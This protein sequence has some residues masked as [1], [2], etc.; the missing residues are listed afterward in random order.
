[1]AQTLGFHPAA[2]ASASDLDARALP[3]LRQD[4]RLIEG[5]AS[6][7]GTEGAAQWRIHDPLAQRFYRVG[8]E[9][10]EMLAHWGEGS[11]GALRAALRRDGR[12]TPSDDRIISLLEFLQRHELLRPVPQETFARVRQQT[13][14]SRRSLGSRLLHGYLFFKVP[15]ARPDAFLRRTLPWVAMFFAPALWWTAALLAL[16]GLYLVSR[17]WEGFLATFP[18]MLSVSGIAAFGLSLVL[19]KTLHELGHGYTAAR[20]G[21]RVS[22]MGVAFVVMAPILYTDTTDA[23]RLPHR[24][25]RVLIDAAGMLVELLVAVL[26]TL[27]WVFLPPGALRHAAFALAT[28]GWVLSLAINLN[29]LMRFDGYYLFSDLIGFPNLQERAFAMGRWWL[30]ELLFGFGDTQPEPARPR[31]KAF[32]VGFAYA[33]WLYRF[34]LFL[35]I[36]LLVYHWFFKLLGIFLFAVEIGWFVVLPVWREIKVWFARRR[37]VGVRAR[38]TASLLLTLAAML[39]V[40]LP[41]TVRIPAVLTAARQAPVFAPRPARLEIVHVRPR[42]PVRAGQVLIELAAPE[43]DQ[44]LRTAR[45]RRALLRERLARRSADARDLSESTVLAHELQLE[46][47]RIEGLQRERARL[48]LRAPLDGVVAELAAELSP[49]RW[50][51]D[52]TR[53]AVIAAPGELEARGYVDASDLR[54]IAEGDR[55]HFVEELRLQ[56]ARELQLTRIADAASERIENWLLASTH[57]GPVPAREQDGHTIPEH[58]VF[59]V[60]AAVASDPSGRLPTTELRG[61]MQLRGSPE[62][63][64]ARMFSRIA[65]VLIREAG[66]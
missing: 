8:R 11:V 49:G 17:Q 43:L 15:L 37:E 16:A 10:V 3:A 36:A 19:V 22:T 35:G 63:L 45:E 46:G 18:D 40:P 52:K 27:A 25:Q 9:V 24:R 2:A 12:E 23:W 47:E 39:L 5:G 60:T 44:A 13:A 62:S 59:E 1:M 28:T 66:A 48:R 26:A 53:L 33:T 65:H 21:A 54:R 34:F 29:P 30:R 64:G 42:E 20:M 58:A 61:E 4:L 31:R 41:Y 57:N 55:G 51:D 56:P 32:L 6:G 38:V 50:L 14:A 7:H